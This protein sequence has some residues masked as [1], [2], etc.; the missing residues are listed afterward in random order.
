LK[1]TALK[2]FKG[3]N[4][5]QASVIEAAI[6]ISRINILPMKKIKKEIN[7]LKIAIDKTAG[8]NEKI[9]WKKLIKKINN[10]NA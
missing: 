4:R 8:K 1:E 9:A 5:A 10:K 3:F 6:L 2:S 7:Y